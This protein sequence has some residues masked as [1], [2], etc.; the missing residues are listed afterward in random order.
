MFQHN[1]QGDGNMIVTTTSSIEGK[2]I[3]EYKGVV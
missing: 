3:A 1:S 2:Q